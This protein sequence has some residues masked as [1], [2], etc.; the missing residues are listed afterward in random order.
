MT[1]PPFAPSE[2]LYLGGGG[3][4]TPRW[5]ENFG[6]EIFK[7]QLSAEADPPRTGLHSVQKVVRSIRKENFHHLGAIGPEVNFEAA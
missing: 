1:S 7:R 6:K 2:A 3:S 5:Q 4:A